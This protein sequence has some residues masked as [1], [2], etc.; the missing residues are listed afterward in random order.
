MSTALQEPASLQIKNQ[1][2]ARR[3]LQIVSDQ[4]S[5]ALRMKFLKRGQHFVFILRVQT[6]RGLV[7]NQD[8]S[9]PDYGPRNRKPLALAMRKGH[10]SLAENGIVSL[11]QRADELVSIGSPGGRPN[12]AKG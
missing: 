1:V 11:W 9:F 10:T 12:L 2:S 7:E 5:G 4:K 8:W 6:G 3:M